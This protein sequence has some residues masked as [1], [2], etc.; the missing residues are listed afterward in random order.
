MPGERSANGPIRSTPT[1]F[2]VK[3]C[4]AGGAWL[5]LL[6]LNRDRPAGGVAPVI[7]GCHSTASGHHGGMQHH[8]DA[9]A[10]AAYGNRQPDYG[11]LYYAG[12]QLIV[13]FTNDVEQHRRNLSERVRQPD[14]VTVRLTT[15]TWIE[16]QEANRRIQ[17]RLLT[18]PL[19]V[20]GVNGVGIGMA[21]G[22]YGLAVGVDYDDQDLIRVVRAAVAP[23]VVAITRKDRPRRL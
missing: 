4:L 13:L 19:P 17:H 6:S 3:R 16:I 20:A 7:C 14:Q 15:R 12:D 10:A 23:D 21:D 8:A 1:R 5:P 2:P 11:G 9:D 22:D 18:G